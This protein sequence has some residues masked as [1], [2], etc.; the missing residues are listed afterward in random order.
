MSPPL[1]VIGRGR[2]GSLFESLAREADQPCLALGRADLPGPLD[3]EA[4]GEPLLV[5]TRNDDLEGLLAY[6]H[7]ARRADLIFVQN[8][9]LGPWLAERGLGDC[10]RGLLYVAVPKVGAPPEPGGE[11]LLWGPHAER[12]AALLRGGGIA[13]RAT[14]DEGE[15]NRATA[16]KFCWNA[17]FGLLGSVT[18]LAVGPLAEGQA[19]ALRA[20]CAEM[21]PVLE[22]GLGVTLD[23]AD[24][25]RHA[26]AY[27]AQI[28]AYK[29]TLKEWRWRNGWLV[30]AAAA[31]G[32]AL[33]LHE[34][35]LTQV[36]DLARVRGDG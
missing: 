26:L 19:E 36:R 9:I 13:A 12:I 16:Y 32:R 35:W 21:A 5:C 30:Q 4:R 25:A 18:G 33:P 11:S 15:L 8:G 31:Q 1:I 7:P 28:P 6:V 17:I 24:M 14:P 10:T 3:Q 23:A 22:T 27:A 29:A 20:L 2:I 34:G